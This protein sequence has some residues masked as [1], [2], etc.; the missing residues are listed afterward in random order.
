MRNF[1]KFYIQGIF[2]QLSE[3]EQSLPPQNMSLWD[4]GYFKLIVFKKQKTQGETLKN[5]CPSP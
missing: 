5:F 3:R 1:L 2:V 4:V